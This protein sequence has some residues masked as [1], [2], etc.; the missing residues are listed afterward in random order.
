MPPSNQTS[1]KEP[2]AVRFQVDTTLTTLVVT[3]EHETVT[4]IRLRGTAP[5]APGT[6]FER[7]VAG[8][9]EEYFAGSRKGP[10]ALARFLC[11][12]LQGLVV[13]GKASAGRSTIKD[14]VKVTLSAMA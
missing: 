2:Q 3:I 5:W 1:W 6:T 12:T 9:L 14:I 7:R 8:E 4:E 11:C 10:R 13:M